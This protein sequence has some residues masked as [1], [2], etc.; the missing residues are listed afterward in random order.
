[1]STYDLSVRFTA[2]DDR[3]AGNI[4][5]AVERG[6]NEV[7]ATVESASF[8]PVRPLARLFSRTEAPG[9]AG[10]ELDRDESISDGSYGGAR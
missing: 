4:V 8:E 6:L 3:E 2:E 7:G 9:Y 5:R 1:M 10:D